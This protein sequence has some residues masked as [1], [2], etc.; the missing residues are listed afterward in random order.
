MEQKNQKSISEK[1][2]SDFRY[3][4]LSFKNRGSKSKIRETF[5]KNPV[6][7]TSFITG[8]MFRICK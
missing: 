3:R 7:L 6:R 8:A 1:S 5:A 4:N 2:P